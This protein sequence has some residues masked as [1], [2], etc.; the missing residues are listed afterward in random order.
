MNKKPVKQINLMQKWRATFNYYSQQITIEFEAPIYNKN[1][2]YS[3]LARVEFVR[4]LRN[5]ASDIK[6]TNVEPV[7]Q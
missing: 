5:Y 3:H 6:V 1:I 2:N 7:E 4:M